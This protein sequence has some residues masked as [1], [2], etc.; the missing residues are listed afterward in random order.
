[1]DS[2][3]DTR[4]ASLGSQFFPFASDKKASGGPQK[5]DQC[6][7]HEKE[8]SEQRCCGEGLVCGKNSH[9]CELAIGAKCNQKTLFGNKL[10]ECAGFDTYGRGTRCGKAGKNLYECCVKTGEEPFNHPQNLTGR[11]WMDEC[12]T[13]WARAKHFVAVGTQPLFAVWKCDTKSEYR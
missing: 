6:D 5:G 9:T 13:G 11:Q 7:C 4:S 12:C 1:M 8:W 2:S 3:T 10:E